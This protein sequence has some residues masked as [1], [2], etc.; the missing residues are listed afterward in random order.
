MAKLLGKRACRHTVPASFFDQRAMLSVKSNDW[1]QNKYGNQYAGA[2][3]APVSNRYRFFA[4]ACVA[5]A[6]EIPPEYKKPL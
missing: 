2:S 5:R 6:S 1:Q 4:P 3:K